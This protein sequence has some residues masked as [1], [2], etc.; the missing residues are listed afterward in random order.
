MYTE[1][2]Q[3]GIIDEIPLDFSLKGIPIMLTPT[4]DIITTRPQ[5]GFEVN[6]GESLTIEW[7]ISSDATVDMNVVSVSPYGST[8]ATLKAI[9][10]FM[11][12]QSQ[13][14]VGMIYHLMDYKLVQQ[15]N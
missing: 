15:S 14:M 11:K 1:D 2:D 12:Y 6:V 4:C 13:I 7:D 3:G 8:E 5:N 10:Y 9:N